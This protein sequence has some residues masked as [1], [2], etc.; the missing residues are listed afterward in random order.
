MSTEIR[1]AFL[2]S[3]VARA[4]YADLYAGIGEHDYKFQLRSADWQS[5]MTDEMAKYFVSHYQVYE[6]SLESGS[7][8]DGIV[9]YEVGC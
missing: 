4:A 9:F 5:Q 8:Y 3:L 2:Y 1:N 7:G 6:T